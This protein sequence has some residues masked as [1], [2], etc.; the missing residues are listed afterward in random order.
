MK[1]INILKIISIFLL[2]L[3]FL[4]NTNNVQ[5]VG[6]VD[7]T[8]TVKNDVTIEDVTGGADKFI[9]AGEGQENPLKQDGLKNVSDVVY[10]I[11]LAVGIIVASIVGLMIGIKY[12]TGSISQK[13]DTK[14]LLVS[15]IVGCV[16][17]FG[18][19]GIWKIIVELLNQ[20]QI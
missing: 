4:M 11:L 16:V 19:F 17:I 18:A 5:A 7:G 8:G 9:E 20:T 13:A 10:N 12:M 2:L 3:I 6:L 14:E 15:Y 1:R